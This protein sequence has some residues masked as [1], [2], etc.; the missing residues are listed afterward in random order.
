[1]IFKMHISLRWVDELVDIKNFDL[2]QLIEKLTLSSFEVE[3]IL[4]LV[5]DS[6][7][8]TI[9]D[10]SATANRSDSMSVKGISKEIAALI[11]RPYKSAKY[12]RQKLSWKT[13]IINSYL[14]QKKYSEYLTFIAIIIENLTDYNVPKW[15]KA[16]LVNSGL[17]P[18][19]TL[20]D[21]QNYILLETGYP[22][23]F[24]DFEKVN[25]KLK[26]S[27]FN[28]TL[29]RVK[30]NEHFL[31]SNNL[32]YKLNKNI[33]VLKVNELYLSI[34]GTISHKDFCY[35]NQTKALLIEGSIF[36]S[37]IIRQQSRIIGL[38]TDR[39][40]RYEKELNNTYLIETFYR[41]IL[42]LKI[43]NPNLTCKLHTIAQTKKQHLPNIFLNYK[44]V[45]EILGP[46][47]S[48]SSFQTTFIT[49]RQISNY[50]KRL[51]FTYSFDQT[52][53]VWK[54]KVPSYRSNDI[55][56]EIDI[57]EE[58]G[59]LHGF[60]NFLTKLPKL[61]NFGTEDFSY[62][63]RKKITSC[64]LAAGFNE[65]VQY[66]IVNE[67][68]FE[69][70]HIKHINIVNPLL[71]GY[72][73]LR[74]SLLPNLIKTVS[75]NVKQGNF[76]FEGF[77]YGHV[78]SGNMVLDFSER[79]KIGGIFGAIKTKTDW[80]K[81]VN[82]I[83]WFEGKGKIEQV[84]DRLNLVIYW[85]NSI[86]PVYTQILHRYRTAEL[87]LLSGESLG[88]FGQINPIL[89]KEQNIV[90]NLYLFEFDFELLKN[91][92]QNLKLPLYKEYTLYPKI[93]KDLS[94][95]VSQ[96][97]LFEDIKKTLSD[98]GT[99]F[100]IQVKL[101][102]EYRGQSIPLGYTSLCIQLIFQSNEK[103]LVN[104]DVE[105]RLKDLESILIDQYNIIVRV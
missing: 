25:S 97:V 22:F 82:S 26:Q 83:T 70:K 94:F 92:I 80:A 12:L 60:N 105:N 41:L 50:L 28:L 74:I 20:V 85:K 19:D 73:S 104:K 81:P 29:T 27:V 38:R 63:I 30:T 75:Q 103:T 79:E 72:S 69:D 9:L 13:R 77:E 37:K 95:I 57:I 43:S 51:N 39:S 67:Q 7:K 3:E 54:I 99:K 102:D 23:E 89:A 31:A 44:K 36:N 59:R 14:E 62:Q 56:R 17:I 68:T 93:V 88:I 15:L 55:I 64:F 91:A 52:L 1:M 4:E 45:N 76:N 66:S 84:F 101:L 5:I 2:E 18:T 11:D 58:I 61:K 8:T 21:F 42:L 96:K 10:I 46:I 47:R 65:L 71:S 78:F 35:T 87:F 53:F 48:T 16:K 6:K 90:R 40:T 34:A 24:Y 100:L 49:V 86:N 32:N 33:L 98:H